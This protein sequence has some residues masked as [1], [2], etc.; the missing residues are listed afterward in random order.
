[1]ANRRM[2]ALRTTIEHGLLALDRLEM[3][4]VDRLLAA[5][6][7]EPRATRVRGRRRIRRPER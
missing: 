4:A 2:R 1:M 3:K 5:V 7:L 6:H